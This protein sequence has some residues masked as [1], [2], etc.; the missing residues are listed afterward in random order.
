MTI[1]ACVKVRDGLV[2]GTDSMTQIGGEDP[3][4]RRG[5]IKT[6]A[7]ARKLFQIKNW[8]IGV[9]T[10]G[11]GNLGERSIQNMMLEFNKN[12]DGAQMVETVSRKLFLF[13]QAHHQTQFSSPGDT[14]VLGFYIAGYTPDAPFAEEWEFRLPNDQD[15][16]RVRESDAFGSSW[17]GVS[18]PFSRLYF[19]FDPR[20]KPELLKRGVSQQVIDEV[21]GMWKS[22]VVYNGM[23]IQDAIN[24][25]I[26]ILKTTIGMSTFEIGA[27]AC[28]GDLQVAT[29][30]PD[31]GYQWILEP[32]LSAEL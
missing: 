16:K 27:P 18:I 21:L 9:M 17:R 7:N 32:T 15:I 25:T 4:G 31:T 1:C 19:G 23:P 3:T 20:I 2:L 6:Y 14:Q 8:P 11:I 29:I 26:F 13:F 28:G 22:P 30:L 5:V 10:Y 12:Y 24:F